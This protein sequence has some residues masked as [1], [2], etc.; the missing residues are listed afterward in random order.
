[1]ATVSQLADG[2]VLPR[3]EDALVSQTL[4]KRD[5]NRGYH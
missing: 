5:T 2:K 1:M 4:S 3:K